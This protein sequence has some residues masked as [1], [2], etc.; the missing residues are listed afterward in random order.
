MTDR[1]MLELAAKAIGLGVRWEEVHG[2]FWIEMGQ[3]LP[4]NTWNPLTSS[5]DAFE[6]AAKLS[7]SIDYFDGVGEA[8]ATSYDGVYEAY[9]PY[10]DNKAAAARRAVT[11][12][13]AAIQE[14]KEGV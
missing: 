8:K 2:C 10:G 13:A 11:E 4:I 5:E 7:I 9:A 6:L 1:E 14:A 3:G 12:C